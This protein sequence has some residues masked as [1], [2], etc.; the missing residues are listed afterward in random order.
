MYFSKPSISIACLILAILAA[1]ITPASAQWID[2]SSQACQQCLLT[3]RNSQVADCK[4]IPPD[5]NDSK[6]YLARVCQCGAAANTTWIQ[7][8]T[9]PDACND[10]TSYI[11]KRAYAGVKRGCDRAGLLSMA[12]IPPLTP[13]IAEEEIE[14]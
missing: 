1:F 7:S 3:A 6:T 13:I 4:D 12:D 14:N 9:K 5:P 8:C 10:T 2:D 11:L